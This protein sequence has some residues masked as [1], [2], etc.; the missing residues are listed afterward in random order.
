MCG[1]ARHRPRAPREGT[2][3]R[4]RADGGWGRLTGG[5]RMEGGS[6]HP[7][8]WA[9]PVVRAPG[10]A[11]GVEAGLRGPGRGGRRD[12]GA[13]ACPSLLGPGSH[14]SEPQLGFLGV[15]GPCGTVAGSSRFTDWNIPSAHA[16]WTLAPSAAPRKLA[17]GLLRPRAC[18]QTEEDQHGEPCGSRPDRR[19][20][21]ATPGDD[22]TSLGSGSALG[23]GAP[24]FRAGWPEPAQPWP[25][26]AASDA[27][28]PPRVWAA[29]PN[30]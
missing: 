10:G 16:A 5:E 12:A 14:S 4:G 25:L 30:S 22:V 3:G 13:H 29:T 28:R 15:H 18:G 2:P 20:G 1:S 26:R 8:A 7:R 23:T 21:R 6:P 19:A 17:P 24:A 11:A 27:Q 9:S